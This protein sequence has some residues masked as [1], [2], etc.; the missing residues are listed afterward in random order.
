MEYQYKMWIGHKKSPRE[1]SQFQA[2]PFFLSN[3]GRE[4][5]KEGHQKNLFFLRVSF[6]SR[7]HLLHPS[8]PPPARSFVGDE[9]VFLLLPALHFYSPEGFRYQPACLGGW[10]NGKRNS[11]Y[12]NK[13][14]LKILI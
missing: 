5:E 2:R 3:P 10:K 6:L 1:F 11:L 13:K 12:L 7:F 14:A 8:S 9:K 4:K